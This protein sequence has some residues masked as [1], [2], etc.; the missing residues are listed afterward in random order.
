M[1]TQYHRGPWTVDQAWV[2]LTSFMGQL[3]LFRVYVASIGN[4]S[5]IDP[6]FHQV[7]IWLCPQ[8]DIIQN[9]VSFIWSKADM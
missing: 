3:P 5:C 4:F 1:H 6:L 9:S 8:L 2:G 7:S